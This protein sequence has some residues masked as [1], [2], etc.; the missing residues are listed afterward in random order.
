MLLKK[1][2]S[3]GPFQGYFKYK[4]LK[5]KSKHNNNKIV[6][7]VYDNIRKIF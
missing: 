7:I 1:N 6:K 2:I 3:K 4:P 5:N